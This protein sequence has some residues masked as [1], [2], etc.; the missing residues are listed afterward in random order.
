MFE[1][2]MTCKFSQGGFANYFQEK[3]KDFNRKARKVFA[4]FAKKSEG[5]V[6][7]F[8]FFAVKIFDSARE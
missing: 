6:P 8:A 1:D 3:T 7:F 5:L 2:A 4:K